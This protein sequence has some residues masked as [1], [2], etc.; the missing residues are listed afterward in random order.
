M[1]RASIVL[2]LALSLG[3][4]AFA[5]EFP[6]FAF[7]LGAGFTSPTATAGDRLDQG[8]NAEAGAGVNLHPNLGLKVDFRYNSFGINSGTLN[9]LGFPG[10]D[11]R[12]WSLTLDP[13]V[14]LNP[15]GPVD[16]YLTGGGGL[17][18]WNQQFTRPA[19]ATFTGFD[20]YLGIF[21]PTAVPVTQVISS[22]SVYKPGWDGGAG[23]AFGTRWNAQVY[24][25]ARFSRMVFGNDRY[26]DT[27]PVSFGIRW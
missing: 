7:N 23:L 19:T 26:V 5:Q 24:A 2:S 11:G 22:Y 17:Y 4:A 10:G 13:V 27:V 8:W 3:G 1:K 14:H 9:A 16:L 6:R 15:R 21:Y 18:H 25:E 20:P 12:L